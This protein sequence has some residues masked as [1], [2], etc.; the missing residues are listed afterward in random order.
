MLVSLKTLKNYVD[1]SGLDGNEIANGLTF[2]GIEV[3]EVTSLASGTG[4]VIGH[5]LECEAHPDSDHLHVLKVDLGDGVKQIVC[6]APNARKGLKVIVAT[7]T[8]LFSIN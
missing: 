6:G 2:A 3:E 1:I 5:I 7:I 4:L 8:C